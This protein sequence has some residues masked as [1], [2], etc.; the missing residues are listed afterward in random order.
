M[1]SKRAV[2]RHDSVAKD[3]I[4]KVADLLAGCRCDR[5]AFHASRKRHGLSRVAHMFEAVS[6][7]PIAFQ[8]IAVAKVGDSGAANP[9]KPRNRRG[10]RQF[11]QCEVEPLA[12]AFKRGAVVRRAKKD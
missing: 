12:A 3:A 2:Q 10:V 8:Q 4:M 1:D 6:S 9:A 7:L 5:E 11:S